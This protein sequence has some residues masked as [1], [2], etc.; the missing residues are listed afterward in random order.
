MLS[1]NFFC[2]FLCYTFWFASQTK[3][4]YA[5]F[6]CIIVYMSLVIISKDKLRKSNLS[7]LADTIYNNFIELKDIP[8]LMHNKREIDK[9]LLSDRPQVYFYMINGKI[10]SYLIGEIM[11]L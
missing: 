9:V 11:R 10:A 7:L 8:K 5:F 4:C 3:K 2:Q 6:T 1:S